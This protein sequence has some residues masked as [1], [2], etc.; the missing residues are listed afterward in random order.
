V[1][2]ALVREGR[3]LSFRHLGSRLFPDWQFAAGLSDPAMQALGALASAFAGDLPE[4]HIWMTSPS[5]D[6][7][8]RRPV[9]VFA[10]GYFEDVV[11]AA[12]ALAAA[13]R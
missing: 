6:L 4:M 5:S 8:G 10:R 13:G 1:L 3:L 7:G 12:E 2:A 9:A 11:T